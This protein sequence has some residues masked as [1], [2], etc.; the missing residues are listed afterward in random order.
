MATHP[1]RPTPGA[2]PH[3]LTSASGPHADSYLKRDPQDVCF[4]KAE[5][6]EHGSSLAHVTRPPAFGQAAGEAGGLS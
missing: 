4:H 5:Y 6:P 2:P 3:Q 1:W